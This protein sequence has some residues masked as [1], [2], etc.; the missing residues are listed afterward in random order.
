MGL[1]KISVGGTLKRLEERLGIQLIERTTRSMKLTDAGR[2]Y[3]QHYGRLKEE[4]K[5][6]RRLVKGEAVAEAA[7]SLQG[8]L[9][10]FAPH[11]LGQRF[12]AQ[13]LSAFLVHNAKLSVSLHLGEEPSI[14][15]G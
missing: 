5:V 2:R 4:L 1:S 8:A 12:L 7:P 10:I 3:Y 9:K 14:V 13:R 11:T 6:A 15:G